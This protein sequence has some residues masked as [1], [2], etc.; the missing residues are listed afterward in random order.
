MKYFFYLQTFLSIE[1]LE[2][3]EN[4]DPSQEKNATD[5]VTDVIQQLLELSEQQCPGAPVTSQVNRQSFAI[6]KTSELLSGFCCA[7]LLV[8][9][10]QLPF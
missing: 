8:I 10:Q 2:N 9:I 3:S 1:K 5:N 7:D 6:C 4:I